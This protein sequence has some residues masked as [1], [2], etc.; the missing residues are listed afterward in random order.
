[1]D[2]KLK[3]RFVP[4]NLVEQLCLTIMLTGS[5][6]RLSVPNYLLVAYPGVLVGGGGDQ[7]IYGLR[8][9]DR[10]DARRR[11]RPTW[12]GDGGPPP[13]RFEKCH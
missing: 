5:E 12:G 1:M 10:S 4:R 2:I 6:G 7:E 11:P 9:A 8:R 3:R 13:R